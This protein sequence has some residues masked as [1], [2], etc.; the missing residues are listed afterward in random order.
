M[1]NDSSNCYGFFIKPFFKEVKNNF[2]QA[3]PKNSR[4]WEK[5]TNFLEISYKMFDKVY[6]DY[7]KNLNDKWQTINSNNINIQKLLIIK[8]IEQLKR[9][10]LV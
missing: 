5:K 2:M 8:K 6:T 7:T 10:P 3:N 4:F 1:V 9:T